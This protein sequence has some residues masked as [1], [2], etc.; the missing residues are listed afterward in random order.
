MCRRIFPIIVILLVAIAPLRSAMALDAEQLREDIIAGLEGRTGPLTAMPL[1][2]KEVRVWPH[3]DGFRV[4]IAGLASQP[5]AAGVWAELGDGAFSV[6]E[7]GEGLFRVSDFT[8]LDEVRLIGPD[9][10]SLGLLVYRLERFDG[11]WSRDLVNFL[12]VDFLARDFR[13]AATDASLKISLDRL[14]A[15]NRASRQGDGRYDIEGRGRAT[16]LRVEVSDQGTFEMAELEVESSTR[17]IDIA[18]YGS[19]TQDFE[20][21]SRRETPPSEAEVAAILGRMAES[22]NLLPGSVAQRFRVSGLSAASPQGAPLFGLGEAEWDMAASGLDQPHAEVQFGIQHRGL[23]LS[24][25]AAALGAL[26]KLVPKDAGFVLSVERIPGQT[27]WR[28]VLKTIALAVMDGAESPG[29][30]GLSSEMIPLLLMA[31]LSPAFAEAG[32]RLRLP[33]LRFLSEILEANAE[34]LAE[35]DLTAVMGFTGS[36]DLALFG[37]D[38]TIGLMEAEAAAGNPNAQGGLMALAWLKS[39]ARR[40]TDAEGRIVDRFALRLTADGQMLMN[41]QPLGFPPMGAPPPQP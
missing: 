23:D 24:A 18:A 3:E 1:S 12:D 41:G 38:E 4:E 11:V 31:E 13:F 28:V 20:A 9:G 6:A 27:L 35:V 34:G 37:L 39:L 19:L 17:G 5:G 40:E 8:G 32:T 16:G 21:L 22:A 36:F 30:L 26:G 29:G 7:A 14:G 15:V 2:F 10:E 33:H 25:Q